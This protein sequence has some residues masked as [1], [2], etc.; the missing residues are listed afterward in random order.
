[1]ADFPRTILPRNVTPFRVPTGLVA[2]GQTGRDQRRSV[3]AMGR[4]WD[5]V[6]GDLKIGRAAVDALLTFIEE[7]YNRQTVFDIT[8]LLSRGSGVAPRGAGGG[9]PRINGAS[10]TGATIATDGWTPNIANVVVVGDVIRIAGLS[11]LFR[12]TASANSN[13]SGQATLSINPIIP[14]GSSA[15]DNALITRTGCKLSAYIAAPPS[16]PAARPGEW[17]TGLSLTFREAL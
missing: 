7:A 14:V 2:R 3:L 17:I 6:W 8:H 5:E 15:A 16:L 1:M 11:P 9:T 12:I 13:A 4:E 10:L